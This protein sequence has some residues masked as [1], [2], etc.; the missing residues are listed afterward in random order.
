MG[1]TSTATREVPNATPSGHYANV[2]GI[3]LYYQ[4]HG[5]GK[6]LILLHGGLG[7]GDMFGSNLTELAKHRRVIA[8]DLQGHGRTA[9]IDRRFTIRDMA[10]DIAALIQHLELGKVDIAGYSLGG[11][12]SLQL[13]IRHPE[14]VDRLVL[15]STPFRR[16]A[17]YPDILQQQ[18][19]VNAAAAPMMKETP[20]YQLYAAIAPRVEDF[21]RLL[22]KM[23]D[24]LKQDYDFSKDIAALKHK[25]LI[26]AADADIFPPAH[27]IEL[28]GLLGGGQRDG[29]WDGSGRPN[30]R[31]AILPGR[32]HYDI[33]SAPEII[34]TIVTF[35][36]EPAPAAA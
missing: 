24:L 13:A 18:T 10:E 8:P 25:T 23:G 17:Y 35:L 1:F 32:T 30:S 28:F 36:N 14:L 6:P 3:E 4:I 16:S 7:A 9:D 5:T 29:D 2:N 12:V 22:D 11:I 19:F 27:A 26:V 21:P 20:M 34:P 15:V 33:F 31:L